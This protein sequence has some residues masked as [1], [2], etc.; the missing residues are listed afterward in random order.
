MAT[1]QLV[2]SYA[3]C[4]DT[5]CSRFAIRY[6]ESEPWT[7]HRTCS[8]HVVCTRDGSHCRVCEHWSEG[9]W[10]GLE[11]LLARLAACQERRRKAGKISDTGSM[12]EDSVLS[13]GRL[14]IDEHPA[15]E[16]EVETSLPGKSPRVSSEARGRASSSERS[17]LG[18][19]SRP[20]RPSPARGSGKKKSSK[21]S[22][23]SSRRAERGR[24]QALLF[25][26]QFPQEEEVF[27][28]LRG[29]KRRS[30][31]RSPHRSPTPASLPGTPREPRSEAL[32]PLPSPPRVTR[33]PVP[34]TPMAVDPRTPVPSASRPALGPGTP[35]GAS[36]PA[37]SLPHQWQMQLYQLQAMQQAMASVPYT[38]P[39]QQPFQPPG[40]G[41]GDAFGP[42]SVSQSSAPAPPAAQAIQPS[43]STDPGRDTPSDIS[44][45]EWEL[46]KRLRQGGGDKESVASEASSR[47]R[48]PVPESDESETLTD[49]EDFVDVHAPRG[50][51]PLDRELRGSPVRSVIADEPALPVAAPR[52]P[53]SLSEGSQGLLEDLDDIRG[54]A[55]AWR[56]LWLA[57]KFKFRIPLRFH[58]IMEPIKRALRFPGEPEAAA[59]AP[60]AQ[61]QARSLFVGVP[62]VPLAQRVVMPWDTMCA[63]TAKRDAKGLLD[64]MPKTLGEGVFAR[65]FPACECGREIVPDPS[66]HRSGG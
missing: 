52:P 50:S 10:D 27:V 51:S 9:D 41:A 3:R 26:L 46:I 16:V 37:L 60:Q 11:R 53:H 62:Q 30:R 5:H 56:R 64:G 58:E 25:I 43:Q 49:H 40:F 61:A 29:A 31:D 13:E 20:A 23:S 63:T 14:I 66:D 57:E 17:P 12:S 36:L 24:S 6:V 19:R 22:S 32:G 48:T 42:S 4:A 35:A 15:M 54:D 55:T 59:P 44:H 34:L 18:D 45:E 7:H 2:A 39:G 8:T 33:T 1:A 21:S 38:F 47:P 28:F 65:K